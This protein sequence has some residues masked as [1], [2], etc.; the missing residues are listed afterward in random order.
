MESVMYPKIVD[1]NGSV[2]GDITECEEKGLISL[3]V[4]SS[5][6]PVHCD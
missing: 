1:V 4:Q 3:Y 6:D 2:L 5:K